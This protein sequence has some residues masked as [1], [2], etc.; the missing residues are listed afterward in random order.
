MNEMQP[1]GYFGI[2]IENTKNVI[3]VGTLWRSAHAFGADFMFVSGR[4]YKQQCSD[5][6]K[7]WKHIPLFNY[8]DISEIIIPFD[9]QVV[10]VEIMAGAEGLSSFKH[11]E[12]ALYILGA[13]DHGLS[14]AAISLCH[15]FVQIPSTRCLN[16]AVAGSIVMYDRIAKEELHAI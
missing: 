15:S 4:R 8:K 11:P 12:R 1:R 9:C 16:V 3:N 7:A 10:G 2:G 5:T 6:V 13:E 14:K